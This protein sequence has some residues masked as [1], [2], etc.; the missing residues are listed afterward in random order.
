MDTA[1]EILIVVSAT[2]QG[3]EID[4]ESMTAALKAVSPTKIPMLV[5]ALPTAT[6]GPAKKE[7]YMALTA[8][9]CTKGLS[10]RALTAL[11]KAMLSVYGSTATKQSAVRAT[12]EPFI[13]SIRN[14]R[15]EEELLAATST[16]TYPRSN[17]R[18]EKVRARALRRIP[19]EVLAIMRGEKPLIHNEAA[20]YGVRRAMMDVLGPIL[21][22]ELAAVARQTVQ[23]G[24]ALDILADEDAA[25]EHLSFLE[26]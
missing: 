21:A 4:T 8:Q 3:I 16:N 10:Q 2:R 18:L 11:A 13:L 25:E 9:H 26:K 15:L 1:A 7:A 5:E 12:A 6:P 22:N 17:E 14:L 23:I 20:H 24:Q 19:S